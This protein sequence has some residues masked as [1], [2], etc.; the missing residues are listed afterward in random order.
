MR[1]IEELTER[2]AATQQLLADLRVAR[3]QRC[4][5]FKVGDLIRSAV[6]PLFDRSAWYLQRHMQVVDVKPIDGQPYYRMYVKPKTASGEWSKRVFE[7]FPS[8]IETLVCL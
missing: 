1:D 2:I 4:C 8:K 5:R 7:I 3:A 6:E